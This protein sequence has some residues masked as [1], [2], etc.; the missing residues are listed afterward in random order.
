MSD[1][2]HIFRG[3]K[4]YP[5][6]KDVVD[7]IIASGPKAEKVFCVKASR[8]KGKSLMIEQILLYHAIN[9]KNS[10]S[11][12]LSITLTNVRKI[13]K[14]LLNGIINSGIVARHNDSLLEL[15]LINGSQILFKSSVQKDNL[16][17]YTVRN[18]GILCIDEAAY[19]PEDVYPIV[20]PWISVNRANTLMVSTP[21]TK[22]GTFFDFFVLGMNKTTPNVE[23]FDWSSD[24]YDF[25]DL[26]S[27][28]QIELYRKTLPINQFQSEVL[29]N[30]TDSVGSVFNLSAIKWNKKTPEDSTYN[31]IY[32]GIDWGS[33]TGNDYTVISAFNEHKEQLL[34]KYN[35]KL[36]PQDCISWVCENVNSLD[37]KKIRVILV[38]SNS[39]GNIYYDLLKSALPKLNVKTFTTT[40]SSKREIVEDFCAHIGNEEV[41]LLENEEQYKQLSQYQMEI[42][43]SGKVTYNGYLAHDDIVMADCI[44]FSALK[45]KTN[46]NISFG[47]R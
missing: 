19:I 11:I 37:T 18:G 12:C 41:T 28:E 30:F 20:W 31:H 16:R 24:K 22:S 36:S 35:N 26:I 43:A 9:Y 42:T 8:Q 2:Q 14:E 10:V 27:Q 5:H 38:E 3:L 6:Q 33:G 15:D 44:G 45:T 17:G 46:Y 25:S 39:I 29:G 1:K 40:N 32:I 23:A 7:S 47:R 4:L 34:L 13:Y 21:R